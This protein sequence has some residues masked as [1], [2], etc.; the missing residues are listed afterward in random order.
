MIFYAKSDQTTLQDHTRHVVIA[1]RMIAPAMLPGITHR[2]FETAVHGAILH[3]MGKAHPFFQE[4]LSPGFDRNKYQFEVP[5][6]HEI[7]SLLF[8]PLFAQEEWPQLIDMVVAH[9]KSLRT[10]S[11]KRGRGLMDLI[12]D[13]G[14]QAVYERHAGEWEKW[15]T[16]VFEEAMGFDMPTRE[17]GR[18][19]I[20]NAFEVAVEYCD[21]D[22]Y[23]RNR[24]R[25]LLMAA[26]HLASAL[27]E[28]TEGRLERLFRVP[29]LTVFD[30]RAS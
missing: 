29:D 12:D 13:Y 18:Q 10:I 28:E 5:H 19:E 23:G 4:S 14:F 7:S 11:G 20:R 9:H 6:R 21:L 1:L 24:W 30:K 15:H 22:R 3:D 17:L 8:L 27:Q 25:G 16:K 2:E 26:D